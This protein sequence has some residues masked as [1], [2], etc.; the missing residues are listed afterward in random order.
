MRVTAVVLV[1]VL[2][3]LALCLFLF[4]PVS[5]ASFP[6]WRTTL[7]NEMGIAL[8]SLGTPQP[9]VS[10]E[11]WTLLT[12]CALWLLYC[13][14]RSY[15]SRERRWIIN[16]LVLGIAAV[17]VAAI[18][19]KKYGLVVPFWRSEWSLSHYGPF[20]NRNNFSSL[21]ALGAVLAFA[22][23][24]D[25]YRN[26]KA[27]WLLLALALVPMFAAILLNTSRAGVILFFLGLGIW[28]LTAAFH[29]RSAQRVTV[30]ASVLLML[31]TAFILFGQDIL[32]RFGWNVETST[33]TGV[34]ARLAIFQDTL[35]MVGQ[36][37]MLGVGLG[38]F[39]PVFA[40][41]ELNGNPA[42][43]NVHPESDWTW[44][45]AECGV[46]PLFIGIFALVGI[47]RRTGQ[48]RGSDSSGKRDRRL[49]NAAGLG[50]VLVALHGFVDTPSHT[51]GIWSTVALLLGLALRPRRQTKW[52]GAWTPWLH[53]S[54]ALFCIAAGANWLCI[55]LLGK[56]LPGDSAGREIYA[57]ANR[58]TAKGDF[59]GALEKVNLALA[60]KPLQ[61]SYYSTR[62]RLLL[63]LGRSL[64]EAEMDFSRARQLEPHNGLMCFEEVRAW[65]AHN[66]PL[67]AVPAIREAITRD[68]V[69][70]Q[71]FYSLSLSYMNT[72]PELRQPLRLLA[73]EPKQKLLYL[74]YAKDQKD[75][76]SVLHIL[77]EETPTL[78]AITSAD[79]RTLFRLW[80]QFGD[81]AR[82]ISILEKNP[83]WR[84]QGWSVLAEHRA[85][86]GDYRGAYQL[87][88]EALEVPA[89]AASGHG[90]DLSQMRR[91]FLNNPTD[92]ERGLEL[93]EVYKSRDAT[94]DD[95]SITLEKVARLPNAPIRVLYEQAVIF[96]R[97]GDYAKA[98]GKM[99]AYIDQLPRDSSQ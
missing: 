85:I 77:L 11:S 32:G 31:A 78:D 73:T 1:P 68:H 48:W 90:S 25:S 79:R 67:Y 23:T 87:A 35:Q 19:V 9:W 36:A 7:V 65:I 61:Y 59:A 53:R 55:S 39:E 97:K 2:G 13:L 28:M 5:A 69:R 52:R 72:F 33:P 50:A 80:Y 10:F 29:K 17:S 43:R 66:Q 21:L 30:F 41:T 40:L 16:G 12:V 4:L 54:A 38:N 34:D 76:D 89:K 8:P 82:L 83:E 62:A 6:E 96:A 64:H 84:Q 18:V 91:S 63:D 3:M 70:S 51:I 15:G 57:Q 56:G 14:G 37:P 93:Y 88:A 20:T 49:R 95:A 75:F 27:T 99:K 44:F 86:A 58:L 42:T 26:K 81:R 60:M 98:W 24:Y 94:L 45:L 46:I 47:M 92:V 22:A 74:A 71:E